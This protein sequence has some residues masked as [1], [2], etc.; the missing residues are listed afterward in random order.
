MDLV[1][2]RHDDV[3]VVGQQHDFVGGE[4]VDRLEQ[5]GRGGVHRLPALDHLLGAE[6]LEQAA[7][8]SARD[9]GDHARTRGAAGE[10]GEEPLLA[11]LGLAVHVGDLDALDR[12]DARA[13]RERRA[14]IIGVDVNLERLGV[15]YDEQ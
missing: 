4:R 3:L 15:A 2:R 13:E 10:R 12:A 8:S 1:G 5:V 11:L 9:H 14:G 6:A 7:V